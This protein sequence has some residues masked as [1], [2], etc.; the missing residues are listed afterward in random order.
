MIIGLQ[1]IAIFFGLFLIYLAL[2]NYRRKEIDKTEFVSWTIIWSLTIIVVIFPDIL[3]TFAQRFFITRLFDM[4]VVGGFLLVILLVAR[5]YVK[6][7][8]IEKKFEE[9]IR[10]EALKDAKKK[11][12]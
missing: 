11:K 1:L 9:F 4:M 5:M 7:R 10:K 8:R 12:K 3:R 2:L 6:I